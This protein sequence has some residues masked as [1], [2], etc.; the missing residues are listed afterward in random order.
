MVFA[1]YQ[2]AYYVLH[3]SLFYFSH[4]QS[5]ITLVMYLIA[6]E[7]CKTF[8]QNMGYFSLELPNFRR[9]RIF[10][11]NKDKLDGISRL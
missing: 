6:I 9:I 4:V 10:Q 3:N 2:F 8:Y 7:G 11:C 1:S 5:Y